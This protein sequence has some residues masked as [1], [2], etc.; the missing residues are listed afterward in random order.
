[1]N[2]AQKRNADIRQAIKEAGLTQWQIAEAIGVSDPTITIWL[3][4]DLTADKRDR[5]MEAI[6]E[7]KAAGEEVA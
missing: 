5:I 1:M 2:T 7:L 6:K 3:R 4:H